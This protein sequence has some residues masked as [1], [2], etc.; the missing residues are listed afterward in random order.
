MILESASRIFTD[1][2]DKK[3]LDKAETGVFPEQLWK[4]TLENG[5]CDIGTQDSGTSPK[6]IYF[7]LIL[8]GQHALPLPL[9][10]ILISRQLISGIEGM[11]SIG[12][13]EKG[14]I[15]EVP[16]GRRANTVIGLDTE[17]RKA[18]IVQQPKLVS[19]STNIASEPRDIIELPK[20]VDWVSLKSNPIEDLALARTCL[21]TGAMESILQMGIQYATERHQFGRPLANFQV[22]QH[23]LAHAAVE[24]G[25]ARI[26][27]DVA[28]ASIGT[29][30]AKV[31]IATASA[32]AKEAAQ[33]VTDHVH[34]V[35]GAMG[36]T[37]EHTLHHYTRR[38][39]AWR[40]E[41]G[42]EFD[43]QV[44]LGETYAG[45]SPDR[46]WDLITAA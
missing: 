14:S 17:N 38:A 23:K 7:L 9:A 8:S 41:F 46:I 29:P 4:A 35:H 37:H 3:I 27:T 43:W 6:D 36:F 11:S 33:V 13:I 18:A 15:V 22:L 5:F 42:S 28:I 31:Q 26:A 19:K 2:C 30:Q 12:I 1:Y 39:W 45:A 44:K 32:R 21:L 24:V 20:S 16:W 40:D 34:Q 10:E 25:A